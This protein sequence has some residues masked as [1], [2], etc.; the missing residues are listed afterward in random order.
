MDL[1]TLLAVL[2]VTTGLVIMAHGAQK[3]FAWQGGP[4]L[5]GTEGMVAKLG[6]RPERT[7]AR[8]L[9]YGELAGGAALALGLFTGI[10]AAVLFVDM[11]VAAWKFHWPKGFWNANGGYEYNVVLAA[12]FAGVGLAGP[13]VFSMDAL[14]GIAGWPAT[15]FMI[16]LALGMYGVWA[17]TH[18]MALERRRERRRA[19]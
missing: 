16:S 8:I 4:G 17:G 3:V 1:D 2:R 14:L 5:D 12:V 9:A 11:V 7:W 18:P 15:L 10:A 6:F 19:A 13:G